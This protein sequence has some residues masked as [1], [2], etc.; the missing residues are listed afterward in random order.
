MKPGIQ[1]LLPVFLLAMLAGLTFW[2][3]QMMQTSAPVQD[4]RQRHDPD[5]LIEKFTLR[6]FDAQGK[7][8]HVLEARSMTHYP[9]NDAT[10]LVS[11]KVTALGGAAP[12]H[13]S[14]TRGTVASEGKVVVLRDGVVIRRDAAPGA[15]PAT[16]TTTEVTVYPD[17]EYLT[18]AAPVTLVEGKSTV[19]GLG[20]EL[21][22]RT[23]NAVMHSRVR[24][25]YQK[26]TP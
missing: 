21:N 19:S 9:D 13:V 17:D 11:P 25:T 1:T 8:Q 26:E 5:Y 22:N 10:D 14:A 4:G 16:F 3:A 12:L 15:L 7:L 6:R 2:L 18:T 24:A 23:L 20:F